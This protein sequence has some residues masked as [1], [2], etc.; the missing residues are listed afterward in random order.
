MIESRYWRTELR[1]ELA[2]LRKH[3]S[4]RRWSEKQLVLFERKLMLVAFQ[5]RSLLERPKVN[6]RARST[7]MSVVRYKKVGS[8]PFTAA[9]VGWPHERFDMESPEPAVLSALDVCNQLIH[10]YWMQT[11]SEGKTFVAMLV[12]SDYMRHKWAYEFSV[13]DLLGLFSVFAQ[14]SSAVVGLEFEWDEKKQDYV[15]KRA[16]GPDDATVNPPIKRT[17]A[18]R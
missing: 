7:G 14:D 1:D 2:W 11:L 9:G 4:Y 5:V 6:D 17:L 16:G 8:R 15:V 12:F 13:E 10:Y 18:L 3:R